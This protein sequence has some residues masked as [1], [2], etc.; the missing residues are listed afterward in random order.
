MRIKADGEFDDFAVTA[1]P[2]LRWAAYLMTGD[3]RRAE[4]LAQTALIKT[5][6]SWRR[7]GS[8]DVFSYARAVLVDS[9]SHRMRRLIRTRDDESTDSPDVY[10]G[11][12]DQSS[13]LVYLLNQ[14]TEQ[15]R[16]VVVLRYYFDL[17]EAQV[18]RDLEIGPHTVRR[19]LSQALSRLRFEL[20][21]R[22]ASRGHSIID[23]E[24]FELQL[25]SMSATDELGRPNL[26]AIHRKSRNRLIRLVAR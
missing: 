10:G 16:K 4:D 13:E 6:S 1:W 5:S 25:A 7:V 15:E 2:R 22:L 8:E 19:V 20:D 11:R 18:A 9:T 3:H 21:F 24:E 23:I 26:A 17:S 14:L 12:A